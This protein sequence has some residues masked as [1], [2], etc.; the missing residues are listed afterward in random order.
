MVTTRIWQV[1]QKPRLIEA[2]GRVT[3]RWASLDLTLVDIAAV[4]LNNLPA[5]QEVIFGAH[6]AGQ[7]R[8]TAFERIIC[9]SNFDQAERT[10]II[11]HLENLRDLYGRRNALIHE[12][13]D[14]RVTMEGK[15]LKFDLAFVNR[16][17]KKKDVNLEDIH[18]HVLQVDAELEALERIWEHLIDKYQPEAQEDFE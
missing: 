15:T 11:G 7:R 14:G 3:V 18:Q 4:A 16:D 2:L 10:A 6:N 8:F 12:P 17:G 13:L 5:A 1:E 9:A